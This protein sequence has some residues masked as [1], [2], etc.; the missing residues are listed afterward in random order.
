MTEARAHAGGAGRIECVIPIGPE[1]RRSEAWEGEI[2][3]K[4]EAH[5]RAQD[6]APCYGRGASEGKRGVEGG[7]DTRAKTHD[8]ERKANLYAEN[9]ERTLV[10]RKRGCAR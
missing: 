4:R 2:R 1:R 7:G 10:D 6:P 8:A 3:T 5:C 9:N